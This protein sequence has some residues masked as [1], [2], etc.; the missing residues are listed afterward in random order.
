MSLKFYTAVSI[1]FL[2]LTQE[3]AALIPAK[4]LHVTM[5][6]Q[7]LDDVVALDRSIW[8]DRLEG[9]LPVRSRVMELVY[10]EHNDITVAVLCRRDW[11]GA[12]IAYDAVG[13]C[14]TQYE[15]LPHVTLGRGDLRGKLAFLVGKEVNTNGGYFR[16]KDFK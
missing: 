11:K 16:I 15:F 7:D 4:N 9:P 1:S 13:L 5:S 10:W 6:F 3:Q 8:C 12:R 2:S 14:Y